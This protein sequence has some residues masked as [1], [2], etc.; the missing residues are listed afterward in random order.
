MAKS[1]SFAVTGPGGAA[2]GLADDA[3]GDLL[4]EQA[5]GGPRRD[6]QAFRQAVRSDDRGA[7]Q[8]IERPGQVR[9][10]GAGEGGP[11]R[12]GPLQARN[13]ASHSVP[14]LGPAV[15]RRAG[16][17]KPPRWPII[18]APAHGFVD[19]REIPRTTP[20]LPWTSDME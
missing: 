16:K 2:R 9:A 5:E 15:C 7:K 14:K 1:H 17:R 11:R 18:L 6:H 10:C 12:F 3:G 13:P 8:M 4:P 20:G 19:T